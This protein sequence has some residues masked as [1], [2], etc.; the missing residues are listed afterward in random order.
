MS[1]FERRVSDLEG[2]H[3]GGPIAVDFPQR[4]GLTV[5]GEQMSEEE[6]RRQHP[7]GVILA[8]TYVPMPN[9]RPPASRGDGA[10][11]PPPARG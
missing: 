9:G 4:E 10:S 6:F 7:R 1:S 3:G 8:V 11:G 2:E 5:D